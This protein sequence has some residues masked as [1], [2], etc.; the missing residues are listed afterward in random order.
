M[1]KGD[2]WKGV[3][4]RDLVMGTRNW[5][6]WCGSLDAHAAIISNLAHMLA[7]GC[8]GICA[9]YLG[10]GKNQAVQS[11]GGWQSEWWH[12]VWEFE[13]AENRLRA[14]G[15]C[16]TGAGAGAESGAE[17][18]TTMRPGT[19]A[20]WAEARGRTRWWGVGL[21]EPEEASLGGSLRISLLLLSSQSLNASWAHGGR[22]ERAECARG[23]D[24]LE[25]V[26]GQRR[27]GWRE[28]SQRRR[29]FWRWTKSSSTTV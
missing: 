1:G 18:V 4:E 23:E 9:R 7:E 21:S 5:N 26:R 11:K 29:S 8:F 15:F 6:V 12:Y 14:T 17:T 24:S 28:G 27:G 25:P 13:R 3:D 2:G 19:G 22:R 20:A 10:K 16:G